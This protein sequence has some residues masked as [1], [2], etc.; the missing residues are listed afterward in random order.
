VGVTLASLSF[1]KVH[2]VPS[3]P[4]SET[5]SPLRRAILAGLL[6]AGVQG[7]P[8]ASLWVRTQPWEPLQVFFSG[9]LGPA[10]PGGDPNRPRPLLFPLG[11]TGTP[12]GT[13]DLN[14]LFAPFAKWVGCGGRFEP[15]RRDTED[16]A[17]KAEQRWSSSPF[18]DVVAYL[19]HQA[20]AWVVAC[21]PVPEKAVQ[22]EM[23]SSRRE[24]FR[25]RQ[26][27][28]L[29]EADM[30]D[31]ER[32]EAWFRE[33]SR[34]SHGG[35][36][37]VSVAVGVVETAALMPIASVLSTAAE[38][39]ISSYRLRPILG[40]VASTA[41]AALCLSVTEQ[42]LPPASVPFRATSD[43]A[44][45]LVRPPETELPGLRVVA[46]PVFDTTPEI[47]TAGDVVQLG[48]VLDRFLR[49]AGTL[50]IS[51]ETLNR[52]TFVCGATGGGKSQTVRAL[53]EQLSRLEHSIPWLVI[54]PAKAEYARMGSRLR[55]IPGL[56]V[57]VIRP[58]DP[59]APP[60]SL[61]PLEPASLEPG[62]PDRTFPLQSHADLVR[63]L[64]LA[65]FNA[66]DPFP[67]VLSRALTE[68]YERAGWDL[69]TGE[70]LTRFDR[71]T[72]LPTT[73]DV[74]HRLPRYP[75]LESLQNRARAVVDEIGYG[76]DI[77]K[78]I[79]GFVDVRIGSLR[80]GTPG[81]FFQGGHPL[82]FE[83]LLKRNVVIE[84]ET[85]TNDEDKA[86]VMGAVLIRLYEQ[87]LLE[88]KERNDLEEKE[89]ND[90]E[91]K[92]RNDTLGSPTPFRHLT[93]IEEAHRLL[94]N[95]PM[96]SPAAHSLELFA[97]LLAEVRAYG[98]GI[99]VAEQIPSKLI[100]DVIKNTALKVVHRLPAGDDRA[101]V[102]ATMNLSKVQSEY[103]V[104]L[105][106]GTAAVFADG[107][108]R[109]V[110]TQMV[111]EGR[112]DAKH[113]VRIAPLSGRRSRMC[114]RECQF[115]EPCSLSVL[116]RAER[117]VDVHPELTL[118]TEVSV[119]AHCVGYPSPHFVD[120]YSVRELREAAIAQPRVVE[121]AITHTLERA[122]TS[123]YEGLSA[124]YDPDALGIHLQGMITDLLFGATPDA[125]CSEDR[126][127]W[128]VGVQRFADVSE[129]LSLL[130]SGEKSHFSQP[131][132]TRLAQ[133]RGLDL[134]PGTP[135]EQNT[136]L[137]SLS[138]LHFQFDGYRALLV[139]DAIPVRLLTAAAAIAGPGETSRQLKDAL[140]RTVVWPN[141]VVAV[142]LLAQVFPPTITG[143]DN[144]KTTTGGD[145]K[146]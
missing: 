122:I 111:R 119:A 38:H 93:V 101:T 44:C 39:S 96:D 12:I 66:A 25:L 131:E 127:R 19:G 22:E 99:L 68:C 72:G 57:L 143:G 91:E 126:G 40:A 53:L 84:I 18:D 121:C 90:L 80:L 92:E 28:R 138:W 77:K 78:N 136:Y 51:C 5:L 94:R 104:T 7:V 79:R 128:R 8:V 144:K 41:D 142:N 130:A 115:G 58:G 60:A 124:F 16:A 120:T 42:L 73:V 75:T 135:D 116:R 132:L 82:D 26:T 37:D 6:D 108:D 67:Q 46:P 105:D 9:V 27:S 125:K 69:V 52:H 29:S 34:A 103:V 36:W 86:F 98:E 109:P 140:A 102:G 89:R 81:R 110:L 145:N 71:F 146:E 107:M 20:F 95:V 117:L 50:N 11:A 14:E 62:N 85:V 21:S 32:G 64:F 15:L 30:I 76:E 123:R 43:L 13:N 100:A 1:T 83:A 63:A 3:G 54:E 17:E 47:P 118:W 137:R 48:T 31:L 139:G 10:R 35:V 2:T 113:V 114:G 133:E 97:S 129:D 45:A 106:P 134:G 49:P 87:L 55:D 61:N 141:P 70:P 4:D 24:L 65:A 23:D 74:E 33:L 56:S 59:K 88:E 112:V